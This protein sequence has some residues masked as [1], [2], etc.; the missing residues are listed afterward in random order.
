MTNGILAYG[1]Y[2]PRRRLQRHVIHAANSWFAPNLR[3]LSKG[4]KA[5]SNWDEDAITMAVDAGR[6]CLDTISA[7]IESCL[8]YTSPSPRD[9]G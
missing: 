6:H 4:E 5:V 1:V 7:D 3:G 8:L 2:I 9:R